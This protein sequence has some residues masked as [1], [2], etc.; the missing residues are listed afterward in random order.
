MNEI[1]IFENPEFG[2]VRTIT[3]DGEPWLV[4]KDIALILGYS[5]PQKA[6]RDHVDD[7]DKGMNEMFTPGGKQN[8]LI[9]NESGF[10]SLVIS[11]KLS[12]A[13]RFKRWVTSEVLPA[14]RKTGAYIAEEKLRESNALLEERVASL[15][16][17]AEYYDT[18]I[19]SRKLITVSEIAYEY[20]IPAVNFNQLLFRL[21]IQ[22]RIDNTWYLTEE[23]AGNDYVRTDKRRYFDY[24]SNTYKS[25]IHTRWTQKGVEFLYRLLGS[26]GIHPI[27]NDTDINIIQ[28]S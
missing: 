3:I 27:R 15:E 21:G 17:K 11:S 24:R 22:F 14:I 26:I 1:T 10:Y 18:I 16:S 7:E 4:G 6:I 8:L 25:Y 23:Y 13:K 2:S 5:N 20:G 28:F 12:A 19:N 9:I